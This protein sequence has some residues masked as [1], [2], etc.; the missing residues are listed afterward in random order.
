[1]GFLSKYSSYV[2]LLN[3][4]PESAIPNPNDAAAPAPAGEQQVGQ[5]QPQQSQ[6]ANVPPEGYVNLVRMIAK[7]LVMNIP[8]TE[9]DT[10][11]SGQEI[12][13]ENAFE[14][15]NALKKVINDNNVREDNPERLENPNFNKFIDSINENNFMQKYNQILSIMKKRS[16]Y[17]K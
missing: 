5:E 10:L 6:Q 8:A 4:Q 9:I 3:E 1:M 15:Q 14:M 7:A 12:T 13:K 2:N 16:P 17:I 11:L